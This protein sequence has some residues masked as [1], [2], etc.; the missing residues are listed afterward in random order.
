M[1]LVNLDVGIAQDLENSYFYVDLNIQ[2]CLTLN[3]VDSG[4][5]CFL[6]TICSG[7]SVSVFWNYAWKPWL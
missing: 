7:G 1:T 6:N 3:G 4:L 5:E 2:V